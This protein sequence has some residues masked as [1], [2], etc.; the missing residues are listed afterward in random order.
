MKKNMQKNSSTTSKLLN[1]ILQRNSSRDSAYLMSNIDEK[2]EFDLES[3]MSSSKKQSTT[4]PSNVA[5]KY[6]F[7]DHYTPGQSRKKRI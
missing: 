6:N 2:E 4:R 3:N 7:N 5:K 1:L